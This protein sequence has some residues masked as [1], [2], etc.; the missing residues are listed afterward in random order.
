MVDKI[1]EKIQ[2]YKKIENGLQEIIRYKAF[3][4][5]IFEKESDARKYEAQVTFS[6]NLGMIECIDTLNEDDIGLNVHKWYR[7]KNESEIEILK[8]IFLYKD[9]YTTLEE[10][11][12]IKIGEWV[13][14]DYEYGGDYRDRQ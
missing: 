11:S 3:D 5:K 1:V 13:G 9:R 4:G 7:P 8:D 14:C 10:G 12:E 6:I 2:K